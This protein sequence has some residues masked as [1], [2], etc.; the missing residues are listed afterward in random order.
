MELIWAI[1]CLP[2]K[3]PGSLINNQQNSALKLTIFLSI[4]MKINR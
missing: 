2:L 1:K 4:F 3:I